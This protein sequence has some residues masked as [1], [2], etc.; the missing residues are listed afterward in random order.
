LTTRLSRS[1]TPGP[2]IGRPTLTFEVG[3][4]T[5]R[6]L[7]ARLGRFDLVVSFDV[8]E[9]V[10]RYW[11]FAANAADLT[12]PEGVALI[13]C[14]NRLE[15]FAWNA[16]WNRHH[17]QEYTPDQL[18]WVLEHHFAAVEVL[19]QDF[20]DEASRARA[21]PVMQPSLA[22][23]VAR[24]VLPAPV[25]ARLRRS[26]SSPLSADQIAFRAERPEASFGLVAVCRRPT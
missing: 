20:V 2:G 7:P 22:R 10:E 9:H 24:T 23:R 11:D 5:D 1:S 26:T 16:E 4:V 14:P 3:D 15:T 6:S 17:M 8:I 13:G 18:R 25:K 19:G 12:E 21:K